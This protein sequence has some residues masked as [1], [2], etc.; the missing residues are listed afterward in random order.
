M[1]AF[2]VRFFCCR[3]LRALSMVSQ[4]RLFPCNIDGPD[5]DVNLERVIHDLEFFSPFPLPSIQLL[6]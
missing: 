1:F 6:Q 5:D 3:N 4:L 2:V